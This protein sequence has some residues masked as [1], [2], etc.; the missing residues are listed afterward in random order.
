MLKR[1]MAFAIFLAFAQAFRTIA[2]INRTKIRWPFRF[3]SA[4]GQ[5]DNCGDVVMDSTVDIHDKV[6]ASQP[7]QAKT[8]KA[9]KATP[10]PPVYVNGSAG[11]IQ[12]WQR[13]FAEHEWWAKESH[14][15]SIMSMVILSWNWSWWCRRFKTAAFIYKAA[16]KFR[17]FG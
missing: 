14:L 16:T 1:L 2:G 10:P 3:S 7:Q 11:N 6:L 5:L 8:K 4:G 17:F 13:H 15:L 9:K 12:K